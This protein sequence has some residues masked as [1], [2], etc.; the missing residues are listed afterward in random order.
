ME[1]RDPGGEHEQALTVVAR[2][3]HGGGAPVAADVGTDLARVQMGL[4]GSTALGRDSRLARWCLTALAARHRGG[5][6]ARP[7]GDRLDQ[8]GVGACCR[9]DKGGGPRALLAS[10]Q[11]PA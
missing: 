6:G 8:S 10:R 2:L 11:R 3:L 9:D 7:G 1:Q 4:G 5:A